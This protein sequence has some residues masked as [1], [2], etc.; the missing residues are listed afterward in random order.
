MKYLRSEYAGFAAVIL[1]AILIRA[2]GLTHRPM[3]C[4]EAVHAVKFGALLEQGFYHYDPF[5]Y[6]GPTLNYFTRIAALFAGQDRIIDVTET[7]LRAVTVF[8]GVMLIGLFWLARGGLGPRVTLTGM[9]LSAVSPVLVYYSRY[10]IQEI[11]LVCF[12]FGAVVCGYRYSYGK[13][14]GWALATGVFLGLI[15]ATKE[16]GVIAWAAIFGAIIL[17][18]LSLIRIFPLENPMPFRLRSWPVAACLVVAIAVSGMFFSSFFTHPRGIWDSFF[19]HKT[20]IERA[21]HNTLHFHPWYFYLNLLLYFRFGD[22]PVWTE[23]LIVIF[24][25]MGII[26]AFR[27][28]GVEGVDPRLH[29]FLAFYTLL[30]TVIYSGIRY[31]TPW[32]AMNF[33]QPMIPLAAIAMVQIVRFC[34]NKAL[35]TMVLIAMVSGTSHLALQACRASFVYDADSRNPWVYAHTGRDI[36]DM[37]KR[38]RNIAQYQDGRATFIQIISP[39]DD[40][41]PFPWYLRDFTWVAYQNHVD[42]S[43]PIA[44]IIIIS[45]TLESDLVRQLY[46]VRAPGQRSLYIPLFAGYRELRPAIE[47]RGYVSNELSE[48]SRQL[49]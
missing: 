49:P 40:Y 17:T 8:F 7:T 29:R 15:H 9:I 30:M 21:G 4:D 35:R 46:E 23:G 14:I 2:P 27:R 1:A 12:T 6:H 22:G 39:A 16:T 48:K 37:V 47:L 45:P 41:W 44:P 20:Y 26:L 10:Y 28:G 36:F 11:L 34:R 42:M 38:I 18:R 25:L 5:E 13:K 3:H 32:C 43:G 31:K 24:A 19:S 33:F